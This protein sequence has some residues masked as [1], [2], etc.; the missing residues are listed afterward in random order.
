MA[1][2]TP[3]VQKITGRVGEQV[4]VKRRTVPTAPKIQQ[5][6]VA[7]RTKEAQDKFVK[8]ETAKVDAEIADYQKSIAG[9]DAQ[10]KELLKGGLGSD[11]KGKYNQLDDDMSFAR[12]QI[13]GLQQ[14]KKYIPQGARYDDVTS[15]AVS[16][17][18]AELANIAAAQAPPQY[19]FSKIKK[20]EVTYIKE[21]D[22]YYT[23]DPSG[24]LIVTSGTRGYDFLVSGIGKGGDF[25]APPSKPK[26]TIDKGGMEFEAEKKEDKIISTSTAFGPSKLYQKKY[27]SSLK[28]GEG[29]DLEV[30]PY[31]GIS[32]PFGEKDIKWQE[33]IFGTGTGIEPTRFKEVSLFETLRMKE[34]MDPTVSMP[35]SVIVQRTGEKISKE[36]SSSLA[37]SYFKKVD[38]GE[39]T[40]AEAEKEFGAEFSKQFDIKI[41]EVTGSDSFKEQLKSSKQFRSSFSGAFDPA[42]RKEKRLAA[43]EFGADVAAVAGASAIPA[44]GI[45]YFAGKGFYQAAKGEK[46]DI[47]SGMELY[48]GIYTE[49][50]VGPFGVRYTSATGLSK[51]SKE[52]GISLLFGGGYGI[53]ATG[54]IAKS[55]DIVRRGEGTKSQSLG[56][57]REVYSKGRETFVK[58]TSAKQTPFFESQTKIESTIFD[59]GKGKFVTSGRGET[60]A[61]YLSFEKSLYSPQYRVVKLAP[62]KFQFGAKGKLKG[63]DSI[64]GYTGEAWY[65]GKEVKR[66]PIVGVLKKTDKGTVSIGGQV[67][68]IR[69]KPTGSSVEL[70]EDG[71]KSGEWLALERKGI[72]PIKGGSIIFRTDKTLPSSTLKKYGF[73][74]G[75]KKSSQE[76]LNR[77]SGPEVKQVSPP[78]FTGIGTIASDVSTIEIVKITKEISPKVTGLLGVGTKKVLDI[79]PLPKIKSKAK[80]II[81]QTTTPKTES[82]MKQ[83]STLIPDI[84][85]SVKSS[86]DFIPKSLQVSATKQIQRPSPSF[87]FIPSLSITPAP[88]KGPTPKLPIV[89]FGFSLGKPVA[90]Q[91]K[92]QKGYIPQAK[93]RGG[94]WMTLSKQPMTRTAALSRASRAADQ[95]LSAQFRAKKTK[96]KLPR[97]EPKMDNY[98]NVTQQKYRP[99][100]IR[101]GKKIEL[102][103][104]F[105]EKRAKRLDT[106]G[107]KKGI[108]LAK[109]VKQKK[110]LVGVTPQKKTKK[111]NPWLV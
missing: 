24:K 79:A 99:Y 96:K 3:G 31:S 48:P 106:P 74:G 103:N 6:S 56:F 34:I 83:A 37:P 27:T 35:E 72:A 80:V 26:I 46:K 36:I 19:D 25:K 104:H 108:K 70:F 53:F 95:T 8:E 63:K 77:L 93:T 30:Q 66:F 44:V 21:F 58:E 43:L 14:G 12:R 64:F 90:S 71:L 69:T 29:S 16:K 111:K 23:K 82:L 89:P 45:G 98:F 73:Q 39:L 55:I 5:K 94:K 87:S 92:P 32:L 11:E 40:V 101:K 76:F 102:V 10:R 105:I 62:E 59:K 65:T 17:A 97:G 81:K 49:Q 85:S 60:R 52:A 51:E 110:W 100:K 91:T 13:R 9:Y 1:K 54:K 50:K 41:G 7:Q 86:Q 15:F 61:Q 38:T 67:T 88:I 33:P 68:K 78:K 4:G 28:S 47:K 22:T 109:Y 57:G 42:V 2:L 20:G 107:E 84:Q 18:S 75:G